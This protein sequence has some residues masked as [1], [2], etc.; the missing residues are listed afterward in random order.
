MEALN[1]FE[2]AQILSNA[3]HYD[4]CGPKMCEV[5]INKGLGI[6]YAKAEH[7][8][9]KIFK[10]LMAN[11]C[12]FDC[13]YCINSNTCKKIKAKYEPEELAN[14]FNYLH[15]NLDVKGLFISSA[16]VGNPDKIT[17][18]MIDSVSIIRNKYNFNGYI[19]F[20]VLPGTSN[21]LIK[22]ASQLVNRMS[23]NIEA[24]NKNVL[25]ELSS[26]KDYHNDL[27]KKQA[28]ISKL[29]LNSGQTTQMIVNEFSTDK[30]I[31]K[32]ANWE[33][34]NLKLKRVY[35]S[36]FHPVKGT[37]MENHKPEKIERQNRLYNVDFLIREYN[38]KLEEFYEIMD[39]D[40]LPNEDPKLALA[41]KYF[42][43]PIE[44][45]E[46]EYDELI[47]IPGIGPKSAKAIINKTQINKKQNTQKKEKITKIE[48][49]KNLG[50]KIEK[51]L[52]FIKINGKRQ[53]KL[54]E[55]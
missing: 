13:K 8:T 16:I 20:K 44:I 23:I 22:Q 26:C 55:Y 45:N 15:K 14:L 9:C 36:A 12:S 31:L 21:Y 1:T 53:T 6:Y 46:A 49:L 19:H 10:T 11:S 2:K 54:L 28:Y 27:L 40:N 5:N 34:E 35:Y 48:Q 7:E 4:S 43:K 42:D 32:M 50:C 37:P 39:N 51:A 38:F 33:Y 47:R 18:Q 41:K 52:P 24:P 30:E 29:N 17:E 3:S 25:S